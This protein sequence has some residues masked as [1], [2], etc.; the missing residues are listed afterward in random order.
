M[1]RDVVRLENHDDADEKDI[2][3]SIADIFLEDY[4][5]QADPIDSKKAKR[6]DSS[7][8]NKC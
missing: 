8:K 3:S 7:M 5:L 4:Q 2:A 1:F 6:A